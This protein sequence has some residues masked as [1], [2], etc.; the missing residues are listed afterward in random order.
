MNAIVGQAD[1]YP[2]KA[3]PFSSA[4]V[5]ASERRLSPDHLAWMERATINHGRWGN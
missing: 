1:A 4:A 3:P 5:L 2:D